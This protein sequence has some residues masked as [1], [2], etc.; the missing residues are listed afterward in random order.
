[1]YNALEIS[2]HSDLLSKAII[3]F[4]FFKPLKTEWLIKLAQRSIADR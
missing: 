1:M 2:D 3:N 4:M